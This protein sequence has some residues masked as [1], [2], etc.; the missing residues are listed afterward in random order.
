MSVYAVGLIGVGG[1][2]EALERS[3]AAGGRLGG[4]VRFAEGGAWRYFCC[5][6]GQYTD[7]NR[8]L[9]AV[10]QGAAAVVTD[11]REVV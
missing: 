3:D 6:A 1:V 10:N 9:A 5:D 7:G 11:S 8:Y 4:A 2:R